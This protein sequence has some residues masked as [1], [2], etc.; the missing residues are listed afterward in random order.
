ME[1]AVFNLLL[2]IIEEYNQENDC[3][4][5][6]EG[7][8]SVIFGEGSSL[9]SVGLV[10]LIVEIEERFSNDFDKEISL[11][12]EKAMSRKNSPFRTLEALT[13]YISGLLGE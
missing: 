5:I 12:D 11:T 6:L 1:K 3:P 2:E 9:D 4:I 13:E 10:T 8:D 7:K